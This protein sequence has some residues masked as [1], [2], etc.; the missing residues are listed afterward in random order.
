MEKTKAEDAVKELTLA[1]MYLCR[2]TDRRRSAPGEEE[3][4]A[5]KGYNYDAMN[6]L[7][8]EELIWQGKSPSRNKSVLL[9]A[10]GVAKAREILEKYGIEDWK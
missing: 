3:F 8:N 5:W 2:F 9:T 10:G 7:E 6:T 1:L 4:F